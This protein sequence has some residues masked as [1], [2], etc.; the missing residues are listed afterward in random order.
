MDNEGCSHLE[1]MIDRILFSSQD[2]RKKLEAIK[3]DQ[4]ETNCD[5]LS[6]VRDVHR[7]KELER[8]NEELKRAL[9]DHQHGLEFIMSKYR[10]QMVELMKL[11]K[12]EKTVSPTNFT[13]HERDGS[14]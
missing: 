1:N 9:E 2:L 4:L 6:Q 7:I 3:G 14:P 12:I 10:S 11:N 8:E 5:Y 13:N